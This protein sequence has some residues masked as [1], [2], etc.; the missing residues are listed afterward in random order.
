MSELFYTGFTVPTRR[1]AR[2]LRMPQQVT[3]LNVFVSCPQELAAERNI[4]SSVV[5][6]LN[7]R[8]LDSYNVEL[9]VISWGTY[10]VPGVGSDPQAVINEQIGG[11]YD[12]YIGILGARFGTETP[13]AGS[14]TEE[15]FNRA[16]ERFRTEQ[17]GPRI[18]FYFRGSSEAMLQN[19]DLTQLGKV[20]EFRKRIGQSGTLYSDFKTTDE[21]LTQLR[22]HLWGLI[23]HQWLN[24]R[25]K[26]SAAEPQTSEPTLAEA[27]A[28][29]QS[30]LARVEPRPQKDGETHPAGIDAQEEALGILD[31][32]VDAEE[33]MEAGTA[34]LG[35]ITTLTAQNN[36]TMLQHAATISALTTARGTSPKSLKAAVDASAHDLDL[37]ARSLRAEVPAFVAAYSSG[38][39]AMDQFL[40]FWISKGTLKQDPNVGELRRRLAAAISS[41]KTSREPVTN[42][43]NVIAAVP[44]ITRELKKA[45]RSTQ[46]QLDELI[47]GIT[48]ISDRATGVPARLENALGSSGGAPKPT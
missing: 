28:A 11:K 6:E 46:A 1:S 27:A 38:F 22:D 9:R 23:A 10:V 15:E 24:G 16:C 40:V 25:W 12:I 47:A 32:M 34:A 4:V 45:V 5:Q 8:L 43:R 17:E 41:I 21:F 35:R 37:F 13:R 33:A 31:A 19:L 30:A 29:T 2:T 39:E 48:V 3:L 44:G 14:G 20:Q 42:F 18:L 26:S 36:E 7:P